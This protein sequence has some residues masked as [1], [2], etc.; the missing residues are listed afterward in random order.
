MSLHQKHSKDDRLL[1]HP[2]HTNQILYEGH[3]KLIE[4]G[5]SL[6]SESVLKEEKLSASQVYSH[7]DN[8]SSHQRASLVQQ[9]KQEPNFNLYGYQPYQH[10]YISSDQLT[11]R[12]LSDKNSSR[13]DRSHEASSLLHRE[14][15]PS[16]KRKDLSVP[17]PLIKD[18]KPHNSVIVENKCR[19]GAKSASPLSSLYG[20]PAAP[21]SKSMSPTTP[22]SYS[23]RLPERSLAFSTS[24]PSVSYGSSHTSSPS[25]RHVPSAH[26]L[27]AF[28]IADKSRSQS[29]L[30]VASP[31][32]LSAAVMQ[33]PQPID[34]R[35]TPPSSQRGHS[36][37][38]VNS[39][40]SSSSVHIS[41]S[42]YTCNSQIISSSAHSITVSS[43][44]M[45]QANQQQLSGI[46]QSYMVPTHSL[47]TSSA[48]SH[49][50]GVPGSHANVM[51]PKTFSPLTNPHAYATNTPLS[52]KRKPVRDSNVRKKMKPDQAS[53]IITPTSVSV[54]VTTPQ[55]LSN[56]SPYTTCSSSGTTFQPTVS[57][58]A[59]L[60][61]TTTGSSIM[62]SAA[63]AS[64]YMDSFRS[65][66]ENTVQN[67]FFQDTADVI[68]STQKL[69][70]KITETERQVPSATV[71]L[72]IVA[73]SQRNKDCTSIVP[74][75]PPPPPPH[76]LNTTTTSSAMATS[77]GCS[78]NSTPTTGISVMAP[79]S[80]AMTGMV[81]YSEISRGLNGQIDTDSDTLSAPSPPPPAKPETCASPGR[82]SNHPKLKKAW[83]QRHSDEDRIKE[84]KPVK[85]EDPSSVAEK[86]D[87]LK[88]C[89]VNCS[90]IS[91]SKE[92]GSKSSISSIRM[93]NG[94]M[95][96]MTK[97][98]DESTSS[99]SETDV[100]VRTA[101]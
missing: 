61:A 94:N 22:L 87:V 23:D 19:D 90:Y 43:P 6:K 66:V 78:S 89:Y 88:T 62:Q 84:L 58:P 36:N 26:S 50:H 9:V 91:P 33:Q 97:D 15:S 76:S 10:S 24:T 34:Y 28:M 13:N 14:S 70:S 30:Q 93:A 95:K 82:S 57:I 29:P 40:Y 7:T 52:M 21:S 96:E 20:S 77:H 80:G 3:I 45:S 18:G 42:P 8:L 101:H 16:L 99:A 38:T 12:G 35:K 54:P 46:G 69:Q 41:S 73:H 65:F 56:P 67:A 72:P 5:E 49:P 86:G 1:Q 47:V 51:S 83:L 31:Q 64:G 68:P 39:H 81:N 100:Q 92:G 85:E 60:S 2:S 25:P 27:S 98:S 55:I 71:T 11:L 79:H 59:T 75:L 32:Q 17:P 48:E 53:K 74:P 63:R 44:H 37:S 4:R